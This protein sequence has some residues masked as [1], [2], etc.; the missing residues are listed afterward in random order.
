MGNKQE[1][2]SVRKIALGVL[3]A[4]LLLASCGSK[5]AIS[6][7]ATEESVNEITQTVLENNS[8]EVMA[9]KPAPLLIGGKQYRGYLGDRV[10]VKLPGPP[11][12]GFPD[13]PVYCTIEDIDRLL[14]VGL[15][16][17]PENP[18]HMSSL[19]NLELLTN[20]RELSISVS[21]LNPVDLSPLAFLTN[22][23][24]LFIYKTDFG[25]V[26]LSP[27]AS[28]TNLKRLGIYDGTNLA[29][30]DF[31]PL[32]SLINLEDLV[33]EGNISKMPDLTSLKKL[34]RIRIENSDL[35]SLDGLGTPGLEDLEIDMETFETLAPFSNLAKL[36]RLEIGTR[37]EGSFTSIGN[38]NN[39]PRLEF[40]TIGT[41][42]QLDIT[43]IERLTSLA[44]V[45]FEVTELV[46]PQ[47]ISGL[48]NLKS[49]WITLADETPSI[50]YLRG[51]QSLERLYIKGT[52]YLRNEGVLYQ[53]L[54]VSPLANNHNLRVLS[55]R[56]FII[57]NIS[58]LNNLKN[59]NGGG[60]F[61]L[62]QIGLLDSRLFNESEMSVHE[63]YFESHGH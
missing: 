28:L 20:I 30:V 58:A 33:I 55:L 38:L 4:I 39:V 17:D 51:L 26:D 2:D 36:K 47:G 53:V 21:N 59:L 3:S 14:I 1:G 34:K 10:D 57:K 37:R 19:E 29:S 18:E 16:I 23:E 8:N 27:M 35:E 32:A 62:G 44:H 12:W 54:D 63:L 9:E 61:E 5:T 41:D 6:E 49:L 40:L 11:N 46:N 52:A 25:S 56:E 31:S 60:N 22:L 42:G 24:I 43:G 15:H 50:E 48:Y 13:D 45:N 7:N